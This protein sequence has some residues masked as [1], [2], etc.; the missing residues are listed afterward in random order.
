MFRTVSL[1]IVR[2][3]VLYDIYLLLCIRYQTPENGQINCPKH[4]EFY[5]KN[6]FQ[7]LVHLVGFI[8]RV[9][10]DAGSSECQ[11]FW[12]FEGTLYDTSLH[13]VEERFCIECF[14]FPTWPISVGPAFL[15][16]FI[17][18]SKGCYYYHCDR[19]SNSDHQL[20][21]LPQNRGIRRNAGRA[22]GGAL[23]RRWLSI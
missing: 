5:S 6:K 22:S 16:V 17:T 21:N 13:R 4:V 19:L 1:S 15:W 9:Y 7:K 12:Y 2:N 11:I 20:L 23:D 14:L 10:H 18:L 8:I 3:L